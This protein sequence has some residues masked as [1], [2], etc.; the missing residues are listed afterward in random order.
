MGT[1][2]RS[3]QKYQAGVSIQDPEGCGEGVESQ[4]FLEINTSKTHSGVSGSSYK[5]IRTDTKLISNGIYPRTVQDW[6]N[7]L[8]D[9]QQKTSMEAF[10]SALPVAHYQ[11][12]SSLS[13]PQC[14][15]PEGPML[16]FIRIRVNQSWMIWKL[17][18]LTDTGFCMGLL[19]GLLMETWR[20]GQ[21]AFQSV[22]VMVTGDM[23]LYSHWAGTHIVYSRYCKVC[24]RDIKR[25]PNKFHSH[26]PG[27]W[28]LYHII[29]LKQYTLS[30][31]ML[32]QMSSL[33]YYTKEAMC[34]I[35]ISLGRCPTYH[36]TPQ[37]QFML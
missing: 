33:P 21:T 22:R 3:L 20:F 25:Y 27:A 28:L 35:D 4:R 34:F 32:R 29:Q 11:V 36:I 31:Q 19:F 5:H 37:K 15:M 23:A 18:A 14:V 10:K 7:L 24:W 12:H 16:Y 6:G 9:I 26:D 30:R 13:S 17:K 1:S 8:P 2:A